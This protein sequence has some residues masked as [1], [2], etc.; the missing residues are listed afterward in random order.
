M[1]KVLF[2]I[3]GLIVLLVLISFVLP[4]EVIVERSIVI[5]AKIEAVFDQVN[6]LEKWNNWD[7]WKQIDS[8]MQSTY[9][10]PK[11]GVGAIHKWSSEHDEVGN[12]SMKIVKSVA[13]DTIE[14]M[15][16]FPDKGMESVGGFSFTNADSGVVVSW[17]MIADMGMNPIKRYF[18]LMLDGMVGPMF[19]KGLTNLK[20][21]SES[22][23]SYHLSTPK[24]ED[25][26]GM[27]Y[28]SI[29]DSANLEEME[30]KMRNLFSE[31]I[32]VIKSANGKIAGAPLTIYYPSSSDHLVFEAAFPIQSKFQT[33]KNVSIQS[34]EKLTVLSA[35]HTGDYNFLGESHQRM[36][37]HIHT[38][39][40]EM[41]G[42]F[43]EQYVSNPTKITDSE[44]WETK[45]FY[46]IQ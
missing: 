15:L 45:L 7:E 19:E 10:G 30:S 5:D 39:S 2:G 4:G 43:W 24:K 28:V 37:Q 11:S 42:P 27:L 40:N 46:P 23:P 32:T 16:S 44:K 18:G 29:K 12:G 13:T 31:L 21:I 8:A 25:F 26:A 33:P 17:Y 34:I 41:L 36:K 35:T 9:E 22:L 3:V 6:T 1:K 20:V 38:H 14:T